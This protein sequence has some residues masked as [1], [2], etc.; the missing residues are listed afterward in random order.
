MVFWMSFSATLCEPY[1]IQFRLA[2]VLTAASK[3][4]QV[5]GVEKDRSYEKL[6]EVLS[7]WNKSILPKW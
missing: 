5:R 6:W 3:Q 1:S 7:T 2:V 4:L